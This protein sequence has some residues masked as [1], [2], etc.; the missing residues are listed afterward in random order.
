MRSEP[1]PRRGLLCPSTAG[2]PGAGGSLPT[3]ETTSRW[4]MRWVSVSCNFVVITCFVKMSTVNRG[5]KKIQIVRKTSH[6]VP[7]VVLGHLDAK[8]LII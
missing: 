7:I 4:R 3:G 2:G 8:G 5:G 6:H 1:G